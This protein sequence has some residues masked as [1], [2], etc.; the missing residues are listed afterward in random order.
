MNQTFFLFLFPV[1]DTATL[2]ERTADSLS[3][4][5]VTL[6]LNVVEATRVIRVS[7]VSRSGAYASEEFFILEIFNCD[8]AKNVIYRLI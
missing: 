6:F 3:F 5:Q 7:A 8:R 2:S 1:E 4:F